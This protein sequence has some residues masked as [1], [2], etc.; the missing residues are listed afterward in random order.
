MYVF[1]I[2]IPFPVV[3]LISYIH[4]INTLSLNTLISKV[5][6]LHEINFRLSL[7]PTFPHHLVLNSNLDFQVIKEYPITV[8]Y[9][10]EKYANSQDDEDTAPVEKEAYYLHPQPKRY[11]SQ[12][13]KIFITIAKNMNDL[14]F[15]I[16]QSGHG[17]RNNY[18]VLFYNLGSYEEMMGETGDVTRLGFTCPLILITIKSLKITSVHQLCYLCPSKDRLVT[19]F[20]VNVLLDPPK[21]G[22]MHARLSSNGYGA[23]IAF[24]KSRDYF[25]T[26]ERIRKNPKLANCQKYFDSEPDCQTGYPLYEI[27][28]ERLNVSIEGKYK[29]LFL[30]LKAMNLYFHNFA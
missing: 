18:N 10:L 26:E 9:S 12:K 20:S 29:E 28:K 15:K 22:E 17:L 5:S 24:M 16:V 3:I 7:R 1:E 25:A 27:M 23:K 11:G 6:T 2:T 21:I 8:F 14:S 13:I 4:L 30:L 19:L